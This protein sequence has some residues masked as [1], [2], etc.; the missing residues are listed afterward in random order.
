MSGRFRRSLRLLCQLQD[1]GPIALRHL[2]RDGGKRFHL[3]HALSADPHSS[4]KRRGSDPRSD[5]L[6][7]EVQSCRHAS[8]LA[9]ATGIVNGVA[10]ALTQRVARALASATVKELGRRIK[11]GRGRL[12]LSQTEFGRRVGRSHAQI[13]NLERG[14]TDN[15]PAELLTAI[16]VEVGEDPAD[17]LRL[18][19]RVALTSERVVPGEIAAPPWADEMLQLLR[20]ISDRLDLLGAAGD[21]IDAARLQVEAEAAAQQTGDRRGSRGGSRPA[22]RS[23]VSTRASQD[24]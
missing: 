22:R 3:G 1:R 19:G 18:A 4:R 12:G 5:P 20:S 17:Y 2:G 14:V 13:S 6:H 16:A 10:S 23:R 8:R 15:P 11:R 7:L 9:S 24:R 21:A